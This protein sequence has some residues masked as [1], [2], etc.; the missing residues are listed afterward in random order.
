MT[1]D[2]GNAEE[3][4]KS[5]DLAAMISGGAAAIAGIRLGPQA[6]LA[7]GTLAYKF[8]PMVEKALLELRPDTRRRA[9]QMLEAAAEKAGCDAE[10]LDGMIGKSDQTRLMTGL[11]IMAAERTTWPHEVVALGRVLADGLIA[12]DVAVEVVEYAL[13]A[14]SEMGRLHVSLLD[15]LVRYEPE[16]TDSYRVVAVPIL[17]PSK[18]S[19]RWAADDVPRVRLE[20][21]QV[22]TKLS[23]TLIRHGLV[24]QT[25]QVFEVWRALTKRYE[26]KFRNIEEALRS[27]D[28]KEFESLP[29]PQKS[30][31]SP[32]VPERIWQA[33][34]LGEKVLGYYLEAGVGNLPD[35]SKG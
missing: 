4:A 29:Q 15:L 21:G 2:P 3:P 25:D 17:D 35:V 22:L 34:E 8:E 28:P 5:R 11:A 23:G 19:P 33:T 16:H 12:E 14:M 7:F 31:D 32:M 1:D 26:T 30:D 6:A 9:A 20:M 27:N 18:Y 13:N 24:D 10:Q